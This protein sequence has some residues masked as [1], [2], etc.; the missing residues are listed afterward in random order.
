MSIQSPSTR[1][2]TASSPAASSRAARCRSSPAQAQ[3]LV[4]GAETASRT[5]RLMRALGASSAAPAPAAEVDEA[6]A[7]AGFMAHVTVELVRNSR[8]VDVTFVSADA[9]F[10]A[11]AVN[12]LA[13]E[14]VEQNSEL[15][16][17]NVTTSL[18]W[19]DK[20]LTRQKSTLEGSERAMATYREQQNALSLE[21][22]QN[23]VVARLNQ[24]NDAPRRPRPTR[25]R[26][27]RSTTR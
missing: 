2:S 12:L 16:R 6:S 24:L 8:L 15:R 20:E 25:R 26:S 19:L 9:A 7:V 21:D 18:D 13:R 3:H 4:A 17:Q 10:A 22:R 11:D 5:A 23:I 27:S 1:R 14:H